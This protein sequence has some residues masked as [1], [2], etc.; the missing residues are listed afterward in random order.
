M[1]EFYLLNHNIVI[2]CDD[3]LLFN[4]TLSLELFEYAKTL[5]IFDKAYLKGHLIKNLDAI[6]LEDEN[7]K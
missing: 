1:K 3:T 2:C 7:L 6:F 4:T 5:K